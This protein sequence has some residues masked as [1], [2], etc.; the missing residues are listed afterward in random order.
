MGGTRAWICSAIIRHHC[1][2]VLAGAVLPCYGPTLSRHVATLQPIARPPTS[3][4]ALV[5]LCWAAA[6][7]GDATTIDARALRNG[8][9]LGLL[10]V[11][12]GPSIVTD[13]AGSYAIVAG[14]TV[15][16]EHL[17]HRTGDN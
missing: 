8:A 7:S 9:A 3:D 13:A 17:F 11:L 1:E 5:A 6:T 10:A 12:A 14:C 16:F 2:A 15:E 4:R